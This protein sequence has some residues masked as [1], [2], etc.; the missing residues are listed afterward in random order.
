MQ[1]NSS[2]TALRAARLCALFALALAA[3]LVPAAD[4]RAAGDPAWAAA[5]WNNTAL[6]GDPILTRQEARLDNRWGAGSP[7]GSIN[8]DFFSA[9]WT[10]TL[11]LSGGVYRF[12]AVTDDGMRV[13]IDDRLIVDQWREQAPRTIVVDR[14][15]AAGNHAVRVE[16]FEATGDATAILNWALVSGGGQPP[17]ASGEWRAEFFNNRDLAGDPALVRSDGSISF[18]WGGGSPA[19]GQVNADNFSARWTRDLHFDAGNYR[20]TV[21][22]DDGARLWVNNARIIDEWREQSPRTF[23][24]DIYLSGGTVPL[25]L[26]FLEATGNAQVRLDWQR[27]EQPPPPPPAE[28]NDDDDDADDTW[29]GEYYD[30]GSFDGSPTM[31]RHDGDIHFDWGY[32][33][34]DDDIDPDWFTVRWTRTI[35]TGEGRHRFTTETDDG[36][37]LWVD[38][39]RI[40][41]EWQPQGRTRHSASI[42]L[43]RG[44]HTVVM[45][46]Q[47]RTQ[48]A[49]A[50]LTINGPSADSRPPVGNIVTCVP[51]QPDNNA[52]IKLYRLDGNNNWNSISRGIGSVSASGFLKIDGLPVD[53]NRFG[54]RGEPYKVEMWV[55]GRV[56]TSTG[57]FQRGEPEFRV[58]AFADNYTPWQCGQ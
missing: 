23:S 35:F 57:D 43:D 25:R 18:D 7:D 8:D 44:L 6:S 38:G 13:W 27:I 54:D 37:R 50:R 21:T 45:E 22:V 47:E 3:L 58:R 36:V 56:V 30:N 4:A 26:E 31:V 41:D 5:Y 32:G 28:E 46:Y 39:R 19:P 40:I 17:P 20:F 34:P 10:R 49:F 33:S 52:W 42:D 16:Y 24:G 2:A 12:T 53:T 29:R 14:R 1:W 48:L 51:P 9:R 11:S 55:E 15:L